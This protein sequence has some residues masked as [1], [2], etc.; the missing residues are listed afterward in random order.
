MFFLAIKKKNRL[1]ALKEIKDQLLEWTLDKMHNGVSLHDDHLKYE[2]LKISRDIGYDGFKASDSFITRF[3]EANRIRSR[4]ITKFVAKKNFKN[5]DAIN[6]TGD[7]YVQEVKV[8]S[9]FFY[10]FYNL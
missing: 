1:T 6:D 10:M 8:C 9:L 3:K 7:K 2:A 4:R 5:Q